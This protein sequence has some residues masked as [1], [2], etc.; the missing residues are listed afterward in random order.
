MLGKRNNMK[1][2]LFFILLLILVLT[3][4]NFFVNTEEVFAKSYYFKKVDIQIQINKDGSFDLTEKRTFSFSGDFTWAEYDLPKSG[5]TKLENFSISDEN[6]LYV[7]SDNAEPSNFYMVDET[8][9]YKIV[10]F[11]NARNTEKTFTIKYRIVGG[12]KAYNDI[13]DMYW[14]LIGSGWDVRTSD[15]TALIRLPESVNQDKY[16]VFGHGPLQGL[17]SKLNDKEIS[18]KVKNIPGNNFVEARVLF[19]SSILNVNK[20][21]KNILPL[22]LKEEGIYAKRANLKRLI[23]KLIHYLFF[24]IPLFALLFWFL[25]YF[26]YGKEYKQKVNYIYIREP[27]ED[28]PPAIVGFLLRFKNIKTD[29]YTATIMDLARR[30]FCKLMINKETKGTIF[31]KEVELLSIE[32]TDKDIKELRSFEAIVYDFLFNKASSNNQTVNAN[33]ISKYIKTFSSSFKKDYIKFKSEVE[34]EGLKNEYYDEK[35][36]KIHNIFAVIGVALVLIGIFLFYNLHDLSTSLILVTGLFLSIFANSLR[37]RSRKGLNEYLEWTALKKYLL[38][39]SNLKEA[40]PT[41]VIIWE[42]FLVYAITFG[43]ASTVIKQL[44]VVLPNLANNDEFMRSNI[45]GAAFMSGNFSQSMNSFTSTFSSFS[46][47]VNSS[48]SSGSGSGGGFSSGGGGGGG[49]SGGGAG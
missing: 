44:K 41:S 7:E 37:R 49:G 6:G 34:K 39:F 10:F 22:I 33:E 20:I 27:P 1:K 48:M 31:K 38:H 36:D 18:F 14:K 30:G 45:Y 5:Y 28:L 42:K 19:P 12:I 2:I 32:K 16:M 21:D 46:Q 15:L 43:I 29:D 4:F 8:D 47:T 23:F 35:S 9:I 26:K 24:I 40:I 3:F 13:A 11:Y 25:L 17:V